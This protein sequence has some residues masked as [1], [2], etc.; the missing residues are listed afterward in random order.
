MKLNRVLSSLKAE[1]LDMANYLLVGHGNTDYGPFQSSEYLKSASPSPPLPA[2]TFCV[3]FVVCCYT[4]PTL[5]GGG[6]SKNIG[7][8]SA[9][10]RSG[11]NAHC[12]DC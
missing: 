9:H 12:C 6:Y 11:K 1:G 5:G 10:R 3:V 7:V 8:A 2:P 4:R